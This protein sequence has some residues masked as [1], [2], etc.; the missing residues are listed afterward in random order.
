MGALDICKDIML[1]FS[2]HPHE[3]K[4]YSSCQQKKDVP[5]WS[6]WSESPALRHVLSL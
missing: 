6:T 4:S 1:Q 2:N 5:L 3:I